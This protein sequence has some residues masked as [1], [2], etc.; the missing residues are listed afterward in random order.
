MKIVVG[1]T[2]R[3]YR[4]YLRDNDLSPRDAIYIDHA[5]MLHGLEIKKKDIVRLGWMSPYME[6]RLLERI[7]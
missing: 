5:D 6:A 1:G 4:E 2:F 7:R 3:Q